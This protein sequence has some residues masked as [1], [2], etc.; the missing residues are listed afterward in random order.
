MTTDH[1]IALVTFQLQH[2][3]WAVPSLQHGVY[4][5]RTSCIEETYCLSL[6]N[7]LARLHKNIVSNTGKGFSKRSSPLLSRRC[8]RPEAVVEV[9]LS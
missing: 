4:I 2:L 8:L 1:H 5:L 9:Q 3:T 7:A 6:R